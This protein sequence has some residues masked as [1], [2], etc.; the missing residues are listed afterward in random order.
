MTSLKNDQGVL[1]TD[2]QEMKKLVLSY[3]KKLFENDNSCNIPRGCFPTISDT[4]RHEVMRDF[5]LDDIQNAVM[6]IRP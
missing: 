3:F 5:T 1:I 4:V 2:N 6:E